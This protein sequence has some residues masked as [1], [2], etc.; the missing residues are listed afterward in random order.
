MLGSHCTFLQPCFS[1]SWD[2]PISN[3]ILLVKACLLGIYM[4]SSWCADILSFVVTLAAVLWCFGSHIY[5]VSEGQWRLLPG[6]ARRVCR[7]VKCRPTRSYLTKEACTETWTLAGSRASKRERPHQQS[8]PGWGKSPKVHC[9]S[10]PS[11]PRSQEDLPCFEG[12]VL[13]LPCS[14][15]PSWVVNFGPNL[16]I[17]LVCFSFSSLH[18]STSFYGFEFL[19]LCL[20]T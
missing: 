4:Y 20:R 16:P 9:P 6:P 18:S 10:R 2:M 8:K 3:L 7:R 17:P 19:V 14:C 5:G 12:F 13:L 1:F 15:S 11:P